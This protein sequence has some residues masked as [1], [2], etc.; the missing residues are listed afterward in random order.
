MLD[1]PALTPW[2]VFLWTVFSAPKGNAGACYVV[3]A[4]AIGAACLVKYV[5]LALLPIF[6][7]V[8]LLRCQWRFVWLATIP[9]ALLVGRSLF[10]FLDYGGIHI[11]QRRIPPLSRA[12][13]V[14][15]ALEWITVIGA[16]APFSVAFLGSAVTNRLGRWIVG[17][18]FALG[19]VMFLTARDAT[20]RPVIAL[21]WSIFFANGVLMLG[22]AC[23]HSVTSIMLGWLDDDR[24]RLENNTIMGAWLASAGMFFVLF[25]PFM[26]VRHALLAILAMLLLLAHNWQRFVGRKWRGFGLA[27]TALLGVLLAVP[28]YTYA[29]FYRRYA[30]EIVRE[31]PGGATV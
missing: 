30:A 19:S 11:L 17:G 9:V 23:W 18:S 27:V 14:I 1:I 4:L 25:S 28:D 24:R 7:F 31:L 2:L 5:S 15:R 22:L 3:S 26:A 8:L 16:V 21:F 29:S 10:N 13:L 12:N 20:Q 6:V